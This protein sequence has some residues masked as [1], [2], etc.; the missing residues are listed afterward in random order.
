MLMTH[1]ENLLG[2]ETAGQDALPL[3]ARLV[4]LGLDAYMAGYR[5]AA[6]QLFY[7]AEQMMDAPSALQ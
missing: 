3:A 5:G 4:D 6:E 7:M 2:T 1:L